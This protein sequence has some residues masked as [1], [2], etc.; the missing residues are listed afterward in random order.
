VQA[1]LAAG[2]PPEAFGYYPAD[3]G[4]AAEL[5]QRA[6]RAMAF[7]DVSSLARWRDDPRV[8]LHGPGFSKVLIG[9]ETVDGW[10][11]HLDLLVS[12][13][14]ENSGR[15]CVN[16]SS[17]WVTRHADAIAE[18]LAERLAAIRPRDPDDPEAQLAPF[19][20]RRIP[21]RLSATIDAEL[22][23]GGARDVSARHQP[24]G[25]VA[26]HDGGTYL[27]P[28]I[29]RC[30]A[31]HPLAQREY[32]FPFAAVVEARADDLPARLGPTLA[33]TAVGAAPGMRQRL[34]RA[35]SVHRLTLGEL[36]TWR[37]AW[38]QP[39]EG[40]LFDHLWA[41]GAVQVA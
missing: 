40:N 25:R 7:G 10:E 27:L 30:D 21:P 28:T 39:H 32:P 2:A 6:D 8:E 18:A 19:P 1:F 22:R 41:R 5:L 35:P 4:A 11:R 14:S 23:D 24:G 29:V 31:A 38:D 34:L 33:L 36:P 17:V 37:V 16:A 20:D 26:T 3:H 15:S 9:E 13:I 12:S